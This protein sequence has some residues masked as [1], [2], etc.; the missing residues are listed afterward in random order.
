MNRGKSDSLIRCPNTHHL[1]K[2]DKQRYGLTD[3]E[4]VADRQRA[5]HTGY[6]ESD[7]VTRRV[8]LYCHRPDLEVKKL[9]SYE[10]KA[11]VIDRT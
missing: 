6:H 1:R 5:R 11:P 4:G 7:V 8:P 2:Q 10:R 3:K 9:E